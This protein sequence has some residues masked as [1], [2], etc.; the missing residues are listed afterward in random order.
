MSYYSGWILLLT[1]LFIIYIFFTN[2]GVKS[3]YYAIRFFTQMPIHIESV[4]GTLHQGVQLKKFTWTTQSRLVSIDKINFNIKK[5]KLLFSSLQLDRFSFSDL[6]VIDITNKIQKPIVKI[7]KGFMQISVSLRALKLKQLDLNYQSYNIQGDLS[8]PFNNDFSMHLN[9]LQNQNTKAQLTINGNRKH[10]SLSLILKSLTQVDATLFINDHNQFDLEG[11]WE[12]L[13]HENSNLLPKGKFSAKGNV[14]DYQLNIQSDKSDSFLIQELVMNGYG[15]S[16]IFDIQDLRIT[17][18]YMNL[19]GQGT[20][21]SESTPRIQSNIFLTHNNSSYPFNVNVGSNIKF[22]SECIVDKFIQG[23]I[24]ERKIKGQAHTI[25]KDMN[26]IATQINI[27]SEKDYIKLQGSINELINIDISS[28][29][30]NLKNYYSH[31]NG[32][33]NLKGEINDKLTSP[34]LKIKGI[35]QNLII[36]YTKLDKFNIDVSLQK[37]GTQASNIYLSIKNLAYQKIENKFLELQV[38]GTRMSHA[39]NLLLDNRNVHM[40]IKTHGAL[41]NQNY[42]GII[43]K[44]L[45]K[46]DRDEF[47]LIS[48]T[49]FEMKTNEI[50]INN[51]CLRSKNETSC[52]QF[53]KNIK[54][55]KLKANINMPLALLLPITSFTINQECVLLGTIHFESEDNLMKVAH[56]NLK[57][58]QCILHDKHKKGKISIQ[59][60]NLSSHLDNQIIK[61]SANINIDKNNQISLN[62][63]VDVSKSW[64]KWLQHTDLSS[65]I[66]FNDLSIFKY[67]IQP[68]SLSGYLRGNLVVKDIFNQPTLDGKLKLERFE[69]HIPQSGTSI[70][71]SYIT[72]IAHGKQLDYSGLL[73][74]STG[75]LHSNGSTSITDDLG[76]LTNISLKGQKFLLFN[77]PNYLI[78]ISPNI[79]IT[80][81]LNIIHI[82]GFAEI[83]ESSIMYGD[84]SNIQEVTEDIKFERTADRPDIG[85][86]Y[87]LNLKLRVNESTKI[88]AHGLEGRLKGNLILL[89]EENENLGIQGEILIVEGSY[90]FLDQMLK[91]KNGQF[92]FTGI[93]YTNPFINITAQ[94]KLDISVSDSGKFTH[95]QLTSKPDSLTVGANV[96]GTLD[97]PQISVFSKP[98]HLS[99]Q[100]IFS[101]L[102]FGSSLQDTSLSDQRSISNVASLAKTPIKNWKGRLLKPM[103]YIDV[104]LKTEQVRAAP[105]SEQ[106]L[107]SGQSLTSSSTVVT[108]GGSVPKDMNKFI[109]KRLKFYYKY[110]ITKAIHMIVTQFKLTKQIRL[111]TEHSMK[112]NAFGLLYGF[113]WGEF[114]DPKQPKLSNTSVETKAPKP[115]DQ[116]TSDRD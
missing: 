23:H 47:H 28:E 50:N 80:S 6:Q 10:I 66:N 8:F 21:N 107:T 61:T 65:S 67:F 81:D 71:P 36:S 114:H 22:D 76:C 3:C 92:N 7:P 26:S 103:D 97:N 38:T 32:Q 33:L 90:T 52:I 94:K 18:P 93:N 73:N 82:Q 72:I 11:G 15:N 40:H 30:E 41:K 86:N 70:T 88:S 115:S 85:L 16:Y 74:S 98:I 77:N 95:H 89:K 5:I 112:R 44:M 110:D 45:L 68:S 58:N 60:T 29:I 49:N 116:R 96:T 42:E 19:K 51:L 111:Q 59:S 109:A 106:E 105:T 84:Y 99:Q 101:Y 57:T 25:I 17:S 78:K 34:S 100:E 1:T 48:D 104:D 53:F 56:T 37:L 108:V 75:S 91:I 13:K 2:V 35:I 69:L 79:Q 46:L 9:L 4:E 113:E 63:E 64:D 31:L 24:G 39:V 43:Q 27:E 54:A 62:T 87:T 14:D 20:F 55:T 102:L 83:N 12:P